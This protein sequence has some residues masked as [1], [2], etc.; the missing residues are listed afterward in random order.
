MTHNQRQFLDALVQ[1]HQE[2]MVQFAYRKTGDTQLSKDLVQETFLLACCKIHIL[3][4]HPKPVG[5]LYNTL[6]YLIKRELSKKHYS[7]EVPFEELLTVDRGEIELP[8]ADHLPDGLKQREKDILLWR[9]ERND[10]FQ[11]I[12]YRLGISES[13]CRKQFSRLIQKC[14]KLLS[15]KEPFL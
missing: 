10:S 5:W 6:T 12:A 9:I 7:A 1:K 15:N 3:E 2:A 4:K 14:R 11:E 8:L 13:A